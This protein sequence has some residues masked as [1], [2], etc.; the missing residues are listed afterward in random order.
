MN[1]IE[2]VSSLRA[3]VTSARKRNATVAFVPTMGNL[4]AG[5]LEL[6]KA[7]QRHGDMVVVSIF[8]N[9][10]QFAKNE[11]LGN[12]PT[13]PDDDARRL[14]ELGVDVLFLPTQEIIYPGNLKQQTVVYVPELS[15]LYCGQ[16]RP[17]HFYGVTTVVSRLF[18]MVQP[19]IAVFGKK[20]YQ[21]LAIIKRMVNDLAYPIQVLGVD[22]V[23]DQASLALSSRNSYLTPK[24]AKIA[25]MLYQTLQQIAEQ[26]QHDAGKKQYLTRKNITLIEQDAVNS[27]KKQGFKPLYVNIVSQQTLLP[28][29]KDDAQLVILVAAMLGKTRLIDNLEVDFSAPN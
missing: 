11:D 24:Q 1:K 12:Y 6:V 13:T 27:L 14:A 28:P 26:M 29:R 25:P 17:E 3:A 2:R 19:D 16:D 4:H 15:D 20:D 10:T 18:N 22:T 21:Q 23:R 9:P 5:H 7:A 8:V